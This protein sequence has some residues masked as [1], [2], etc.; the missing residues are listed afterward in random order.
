MTI[1][2]LASMVEEELDKRIRPLGDYRVSVAKNLS[3][4]DGEQLW[5]VFVSVDRPIKQRGQYYDIL[6]DVEEFLET[7]RNENVM[8]VPVKPESAS[9]AS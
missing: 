4:Q 6:N 1:D 7:Q 8:L 2:Q 3:F 9:Q 5:H